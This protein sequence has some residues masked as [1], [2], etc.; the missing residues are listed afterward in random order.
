[1]EKFFVNFS[2]LFDGF[3]VVS[4]TVSDVSGEIW[5][6]NIKINVDDSEICLVRVGQRP[7]QIVNIFLGCQQIK[8]P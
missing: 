8:S 6:R 2:S 1:M 4:L 7:T 5:R 3:Q